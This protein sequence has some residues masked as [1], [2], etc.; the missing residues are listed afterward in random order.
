MSK[1]I[2]MST[3]LA[4]FVAL[5]AIASIGIASDAPKTPWKITGQLEEACTCS[6]A[7]PCWFGSKPT[8]MTCGGG[9]FIFIDKGTYGNVKLDGLSVGQMSQS[10]EGKAM[11]ESY[12]DWNFLYLYIDEKATPEQREALKVIG[13]TVLAG[14][15]SKKTETR[16]VPLTRKIDGKEHS[17]SLGKYGSFS[18]H[19]VEGGLGGSVKIVNPPGAD[20]LHH[21]YLQGENTKVAYN[22]AGQNWEFGGSNYMFGTFEIDSAQYEKFAAG[23]A[24]K[25]AGMKK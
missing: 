16:F 2:K 3:M 19:I 17:I 6:A 7:C 18:G 23:L 22:D 12:G 11:M 4:G 9:E 24:Q 5:I 15:A 25:M 8:K 1:M 21:E 13:R 14:E 20:P 10:P